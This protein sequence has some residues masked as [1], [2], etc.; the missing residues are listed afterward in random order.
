[1]KLTFPAFSESLLAHIRDDEAFIVIG[2]VSPDGDC[3]SSE[4][5]MGALLDKLGKEVVLANAGPFERVE[6]RPYK[7]QFVSEIPL[8]FLAKKPTVVIT[9]CST[10]DRIGSLLPQ[11]E[12]LRVLVIDHH[13]SGLTFGDERYIVPASPSTTLL[14]QHLFETLGVE[15]DPDT[16]RRLFFGFCTDTGFFRFISSGQGSALSQVAKLVDAGADPNAVYMRMNGGKSLSFIKYLGLLIDRSELFLDGK[17][18]VT[19][20]YL[21]DKEKFACDKPSDLFFQHMLSIEGVKVV[22][23]LKEKEDGKV[24]VG[25]RAS[26][27]STADVGKIAA[28]FG[29]GGHAHASGLTTSGTVTTVRDKLLSAINLAL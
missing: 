24:E 27:D 28:R 6:I 2:H 7:E 11:I 17:V 22:L 12:G 13:A 29:G 9:D 14:V 23:L 19:Y 20:T 15:I 25:L 26:H 5:A 4:L 10:S 18:A 3:L 21:A 1:M 16:A 8:D